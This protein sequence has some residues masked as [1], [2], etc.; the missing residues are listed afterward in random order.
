MKTKA[1][2]LICFLGVVAAL[3]V[4]LLL[5]LVLEVHAGTYIT[6]KTPNTGVPYYGDSVPAN[7]PHNIKVEVRQ[8]INISVIDG[9]RPVP[10]ISNQRVIGPNFNAVAPTPSTSMQM[11]G[12]YIVDRI[13]YMSSKPTRPDN[14]RMFRDFNILTGQREKYEADMFEWRVRGQELRQRYGDPLGLQF[15]K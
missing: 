2:I 10:A 15:W 4:V 12:N 1:N 14:S 9:Y 7:V 11:D 8:H 6:F 3:L 5:I 13:N